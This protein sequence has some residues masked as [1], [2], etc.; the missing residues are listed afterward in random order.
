LLYLHSYACHYQ[1]LFAK[2]FK[3]LGVEWNLAAGPLIVRLIK[4]I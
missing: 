4:Y 3:D 2:K 1:G